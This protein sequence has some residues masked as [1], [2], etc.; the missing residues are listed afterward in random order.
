MR[1]KSVRFKAGHWSAM[2]SCRGAS[3]KE[4]FSSW[5][6]T[7]ASRSCAASPLC[8]IST[9]PRRSLNRNQTSLSSDSVRKHPSDDNATS[10]HNFLLLS[11]SF[12]PDDPFSNSNFSPFQVEFNCHVSVSK[13]LVV[14][15]LIH[16]I[17]YHFK[18]SPFFFTFRRP[19]LSVSYF[20]MC[21]C[22]YIGNWPRFSPPLPFNPPIPR[23]QFNFILGLID[24]FHLNNNNNNNGQWLYTCRVVH[25]HG[26]GQLDQQYNCITL[27]FCRLIITDH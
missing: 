27:L 8:P 17:D 2:F 26:I 10:F 11:S 7:T 19:R 18:S 1:R 24:C 22:T 23:I 15:S 21:A 12:R 6:K 13:S 14:D 20:C 4:P 16:L 9:S 3:K 5:D 25:P